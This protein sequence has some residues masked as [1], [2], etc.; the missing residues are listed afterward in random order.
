MFTIEVWE[1]ILSTYF[2]CLKYQP[3]CTDNVYAQDPQNQDA[4]LAKI[5]I[6]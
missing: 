3:L 6:A 2:H 4:I 1:A 5:K